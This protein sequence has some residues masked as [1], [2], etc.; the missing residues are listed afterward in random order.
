MHV[1]PHVELGPVRQREDADGLALLHAA[2]VD[3]PELGALVLRVPLV[4]GIAE[5]EDALL[6][7]ALL[8]VAARAAE[9]CVVAAFR[10]RL[11]QGLGLHDVRVALCAVLERV[12]LVAHAFEVDLLDE[13]RADVLR[14]LVPEGDHLLELERRVDVQ[15]RER[16]RRRIERLLRKSQHHA[17]VLA[18]R[19]EHHRVLELGC[20]LSNDLDALVLE[21]LEMCQLIAGCHDAFSV[22]VGGARNPRWANVDRM[23]CAA[24]SMPRPEVSTLRSG[25]SGS[26]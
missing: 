18:D 26:S 1:E 12:D 24:S 6:R 9:C 15:E 11:L 16:D 3:V 20:D 7:A 8:L 5:A 22:A 19:V 2:I 17:A 10:E 13:L 21:L 4:A 23:V 25:W 14:E